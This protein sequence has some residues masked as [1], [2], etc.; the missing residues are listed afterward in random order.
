MVLHS[1]I[2]LRY[3]IPPPPEFVAVLLTLVLFAWIESTV[4]QQ[5]GPPPNRAEPPHWTRTTWTCFSET[6]EIN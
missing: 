3:R 4:A 5:A 2:E 1:T 6:L